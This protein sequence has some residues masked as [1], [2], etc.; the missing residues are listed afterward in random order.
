MKRKVGSS[1]RSTE[2][3]SFSQTHQA[4]M[5]EGAQ[6]NKIRNENREVTTD[7]TEI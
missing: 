4:R 2:L 3:I 1:K 7:T 6:I 5:G